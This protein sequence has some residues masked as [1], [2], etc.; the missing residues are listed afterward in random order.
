MLTLFLG[1]HPPYV[2]LL[3]AVF[4]GQKSLGIQPCLNKYFDGGVIF[5]RA[6]QHTTCILHDADAVS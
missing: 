6:R 2:V 1:G 4:Q 3:A 5:S